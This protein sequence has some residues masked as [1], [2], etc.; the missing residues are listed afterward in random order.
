M[1]G[2][3]YEVGTE[4]W[5]FVSCA[6]C[7]PTITSLADHSRPDRATRRSST[8][9]HQQESERPAALLAAVMDPWPVPYTETDGRGRPNLAVTC[10]ADLRKQGV[11]RG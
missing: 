8:Y 10:D 11:L 9:Y 7:R 2:T 6:A 1:L 3:P 5:S 4:R